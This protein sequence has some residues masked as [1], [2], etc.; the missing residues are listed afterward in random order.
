MPDRF[1]SGGSALDAGKSIAMYAKSKAENIKQFD[2]WGDSAV[3][4][5][6]GGYFVPV[7][8]MPTT[9]GTGAEMGS[10]SMLTDLQ[11]NEKI[12]VGHPELSGTTSLLHTIKAMPTP[13][14]VL[15]YIKK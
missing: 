9:A 1:L 12:C 6:K 13:F 5:T 8:T 2:F 4:L 14:I 3:E 11:N 15:Q 7:I 10:G